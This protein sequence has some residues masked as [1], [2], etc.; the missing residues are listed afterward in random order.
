MT[1]ARVFRGGL[2][3]FSGGLSPAEGISGCDQEADV[4]LLCGHQERQSAASVASVQLQQS[5]EVPGSQGGAVSPVA[6][7][8]QSQVPQLRVPWAIRQRA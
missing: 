8:T 6:E 5:R 3:Y 1:M 2:L 7:D 4:G